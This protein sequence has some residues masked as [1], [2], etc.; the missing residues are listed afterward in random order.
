MDLVKQK[1]L[2]ILPFFQYKL[3]KKNKKKHFCFVCMNEW[4]Q[5]I[6]FR[7]KTWIKFTILVRFAATRVMT[8]LSW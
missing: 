1:E 2:F 7:A 5:L 4:W 3:C 8:L 6:V